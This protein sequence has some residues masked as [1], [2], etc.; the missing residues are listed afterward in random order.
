MS[1]L[2]AFDP[3][4][5]KLTE[6]TAAIT[7]IGALGTSAFGL[8]DAVKFFPSGLPMRGFKDIEAMVK[9]FAPT[10]ADVPSARELSSTSILKSLSSNWIG[11][12]DLPSQKAIAKTLIKLRFSAKN[13]P[14]L[15][16]LTGLDASLLTNVAEKLN[17]IIPAGSVGQATVAATVEGSETPPDP[18]DPL[19]LTAPEQDVYGRFDV[20]LSSAIDQAYESAMQTYVSWAKVAAGV[21]SIVLAEAAA[22]ALGHWDAYGKAFLVGLIATPLAPIAKDLSTALTNAANAVQSVKQ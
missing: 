20:L 2:F 17:G 5:V 21:V 12:K 14:K 15:A 4:N 9:E 11:G 19:G 22:T 10:A 13:A 1:F 7:A 3:A 16:A 8:V 6:V 18:I